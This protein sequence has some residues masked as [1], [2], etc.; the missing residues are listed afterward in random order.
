MKK[1]S[2]I[3][4]LLFF[5]IQSYAQVWQWSVQV[6]PVI[7]SETKD[8]PVAFLWIPENC[9]QVRGVVVGQHNMIEEGIFEHP[10]F[11][12]AMTEIGFAIVW[13]SP[14]LS[15]NFDFN[16]DAGEHFNYMMKK[17]ADSSGYKEFA[18]APVVPVGHSA[19]A[20]YPWN[21]A[22][23]NPERT[24]AV[25]SIHGD[26]PQTHLTGYGGPNVTWGSRNM[27]GVPGLMVMGEYEW[28]EDRMA[29][30]FKY[31]SN[32]PKTPITF[33]CDAGHG[34]FDYSNALVKYLAL[35]I[36]KAAAYRLPAAMSL[37]KPVALKFIDPVSGWLMDRWR[38]DSLPTAM[39]ASY[40]NYKGERYVASWCFDKEQ[41]AATER[42]YASARGKKQQ[43]F[44][45]RKN[46]E[47][48]HP[49]TSHAAYNLTYN[50]EKDGITF[51]ISA[52]FADTTRLVAVEEHA[53]TR[54]QINKIT[55]PV[56]KIDDSTFQIAFDRVGCNNPKRSGD[57]W[58]IA[59]NEGDATYKSAV[60]QAD[61]HIPVFNTEGEEQQ[62]VF[63]AVADQKP[64]I[65]SIPLK[66]TSTAGVPVHF[67]VKEGPAEVEGSQLH[68]STIPPRAKFPLRVT[69]VAWQYGSN[70]APKLKSARPVER[71]FYIQ[72]R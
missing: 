9:K 26:A 23:W 40:Q 22:A 54:L 3:F 4:F 30:G 16:K 20:T 55:G 61:L 34:H 51:H 2:L 52:F 39:P 29:P 18:Y 57:I 49:V 13:V 32:H 69:V 14:M 28:W 6:D 35:Y 12:K 63:D 45:F 10:D 68:F 66:A 47:V 17:L 44:G 65:R 19:A 62:I 31:V 1:R 64:G 7:S 42:L 67:Y 5:S 11:R 56:K 38:K 15:M 46:G 72:C 21:F 70:A 25:I 50:P 59:E 43:Y 24:L 58:L 53:K 33:F 36:K 37:N 41:C 48:I 8:H 27:D 60:Q 71:T